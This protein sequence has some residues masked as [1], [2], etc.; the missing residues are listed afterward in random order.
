M[1]THQLREFGLYAGG[2][3]I[4]NG[5]H[6]VKTVQGRQPIRANGKLLVIDGGFCSAYHPATRH[7]RLHPFP[8]LPSSRGM[9]IKAHGARSRAWRKPSPETPTSK[10]DHQL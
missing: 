6:P 3:L 2:Q 9:R 1:R 5:P 10:R 4:I 8:I 7:R